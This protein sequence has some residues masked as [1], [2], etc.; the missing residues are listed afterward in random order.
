MAQS[1]APFGFKPWE[2]VIHAGLYCVPTAPT[3][4]IMLQDIVAAD[5]T[6][7]AAT[8]GNGLAVAT[9]ADT[10]IISTTVGAVLIGS[11]LACF[12]EK[13]DPILYIPAARVGDGTVAGYVLVA[14]SPDQ[15][16]LAQEDSVTDDIALADVGL[17]FEIYSPGVSLG[18]T[19]T[20]ISKQMID[21][22]SH[23]TTITISVKVLAAHPDDNPVND[24]YSRW[25]C[26]INAHYLGSN[27]AA[28]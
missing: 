26:K 24:H 12:D 2:R 11:V 9:I 19:T 10:G 6:A 21:S 20:G 23:N 7:I 1:S 3:L 25:I 17:N 15:L 4:N 8:R 28:V 22:N 5:P 13:M 14:D 27:A 16:Y 18:N